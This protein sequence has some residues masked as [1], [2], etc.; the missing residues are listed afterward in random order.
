MI[1]VK[2]T[3]KDNLLFNRKLVLNIFIVLIAIFLS[4]FIVYSQ[5][6]D[7]L[8]IDRMDL[9]YIALC[10]LSFFLILKR[11]V[12][13]ITMVLS[14]LAIY[15]LLG[16]VPHFEIGIFNIFLGDILAIIFTVATILRLSLNTQ[17]QT[18]V[19]S[20][21]WKLFVI[22]SALA[23]VSILRGLPHYGET[24]MVHA[25]EHIYVITATAYF[26]TFRFDKSEIRRIFPIFVVF[27]ILLLSIACLRWLGILAPREGSLIYK[28][29]WLGQ[30]MLNRYGAFYLVFILYVFVVSKINRMTKKNILSWIVIIGTIVAIILNQVRTTWVLVFVGSLVLSFKYRLRFI[31]KALIVLLLFLILIPFLW[32]YQPRP[33]LRI[34]SYL[35]T[36]AT[37]F[38]KPEHTTFSFRIESNKAYLKKMSLKEYILGVPFGTPISYVIEGQVR[39][40]GVH[41]MFVEQI[42]RTGIFGLVIFALL[43][44][45]LIRG[46]NELIKIEN[47]KLI[48]NGLIILWITLIC[49]QVNFMAWTADFLYPVILGISMSMIAHYG[50]NKKAEL[51]NIEN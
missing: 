18:I 46:I 34:S 11:P 49:Y 29:T 37:V 43:Q 35:Y 8:Y 3:L 10:I 27:G 45:S 42:Y 23:I 32:F 30:R 5:G 7:L 21:P 6:M 2:D 14:V 39:Q 36:A 20:Y 16:Y 9:L 1:K 33:V 51:A 50:Y 13:A 25:R 41:N 17:S 38:W 15:Q 31:G 4:R 19:H 28:G 24:T 12:I 26:C 40:T 22:F 48:K 44:I 47:D